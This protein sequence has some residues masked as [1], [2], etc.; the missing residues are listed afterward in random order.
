MIISYD[1]VK[2]TN[3]KVTPKEKAQEILLQSMQI[4]FVRMSDAA[5]EDI[6]NMTDREKD[7]VWKQMDKQ[8]ARI[9]KMFGCEPHSFQRGC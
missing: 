4:A 2:Q 8:M 9:E 5:S 6:S 3:V 7:L 1:S